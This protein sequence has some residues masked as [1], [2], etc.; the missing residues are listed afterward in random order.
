MDD[1][2]NETGLTQETFTLAAA[3]GARVIGVILILFLAFM[4][5]GWAKR[6]VVSR[7]T[8]VGFDATLTK[9]L[10]SATRWAIVLFAILG[11][12]GI[13]GIETTSFAAVIGGAS[14][15]IGLAFQGSLSNVAAGAMLLLFR[16]YTVGDVINIAGTTGIVDCIDLF[17][18]TIDTFDNRRIIVP[19][20]KVFG[21]TIENITY[22]DVRRADVG[23]GVGY[24][25]DIEHTREILT[26]AARSV[27]GQVEDREPEVVLLDL[28]GSSVDWSVRVWAPTADFGAVR[29]R[30]ITAVKAALEAADIDIPYPHTVFV[31]KNG[32]APSLP[33]TLPSATVSGPS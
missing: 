26:A 7:L 1:F 10:G 9:F 5:A 6:L 8:K 25:A 27:E 12:L 30:T 28:G 13:F 15:A 18:T 14:L 3:W 29:Q 4:V 16:P 31:A 19:N 33:A 32:A 21:N 24:E 20:G 23:V 11:C 2:L 17:M 22:H